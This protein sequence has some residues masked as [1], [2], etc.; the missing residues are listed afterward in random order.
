MDISYLKKIAPALALV[1]VMLHSCKPDLDYDIKGYTQKII[2]EATIGDGTFPVVHLSLNNPTWKTV[3]SNTILNNVIRYAKVTVSDGTRSEILTSG[4]D[5]QHFPPYKYYGTELRGQAGKNYSIRIDYSG[6]TVG[7]ETSIP[8]PGEITGFDTEALTAND[9]LRKLFMTLDMKDQPARGYLIESM[10]LKDKVYAKVKIVYNPDLKL[11][12]K[13]R[14]MIS[15]ET[16]TE[17]KKI[18]NAPYYCKGDTIIIR[19]MTI[20]STSTAFFNDLSMFSSENGIA[21]MV[22]TGEKQKI[23][24]NI[25]NPGFGIWYGESSTYYQFIIP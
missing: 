5:P 20:D 23:H 16:Q 9:S 6:L 7:S 17:G 14:Y 1:V 11:T 19:L 25:N 10:N 12:G 2:V 24:S 13:H 22:I 21:S 4:W 3:D 8:L 15:P 18:R